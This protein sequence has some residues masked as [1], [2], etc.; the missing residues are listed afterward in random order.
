MT[1]EKLKRSL[2]WFLIVLMVSDIL[3][4]RAVAYSEQEQKESGVEWLSCPGFQLLP[5]EDWADRE[6]TYELEVTGT[7]KELANGVEFF[8]DIPGINMKPALSETNISVSDGWSYEFENRIP[9]GW[10]DLFQHYFHSFAVKLHRPGAG[11]GIASP[12]GADAVSAAAG[13][14]DILDEDGYIPEEELEDEEYAEA[15][16]GEADTESAG[17]GRRAA[18]RTATASVSDQAEDTGL[19]TVVITVTVPVGDLEIHPQFRP[20]S[21][22]SLSASLAGDG[23]KEV[24]E[25]EFDWERLGTPSDYTGF[26]QIVFWTDNHDEAEKRASVD[27]FK[28]MLA[29]DSNITFTVDGKTYPLNETTMRYV[30]IDELPQPEIVKDGE[31]CYRLAYPDDTFPTKLETEDGPHDV[32]WTFTQPQREGYDAVKVDENNF[33]NY[34]SLHDR[35]E[36][37]YGWYYILET[38]VTFDAVLRTGAS[39]DDEDPG[40]ANFN[41]ESLKN[42]LLDNYELEIIRPYHASMYIPLASMNEDND[43]MKFEVSETDSKTAK[44][45]VTN[46]WKYNIDGSR[47]QYRV[48]RTDMGRIPAPEIDTGDAPVGVGEDYLAPFYDNSGTNYASDTESVRNGGKLYL[49]LT[50]EA[51][52]NATKEWWDSGRKGINRPKG[53]FELWRYRNGQDYA[54]AAPVRDNNDKIVQC[55]LDNINDRQQIHFKADDIADLSS[56]PKYDPEGY[57]YVYVV[58]EYLEGADANHYQQ[59]FGEIDEE[60]AGSGVFTITDTLPT[61]LPPVGTGT[62]TGVRD[63]N[64]SYLYNGGVLSNCLNKNINVRA[65]KRW[66]S[67]AFQSG[68]EN[69]IV[70]MTLQS[71]PKTPDND[72]LWSTARDKNNQD[73]RMVKYGFTEED[74]AAWGMGASV[75]EYGLLGRELEYRWVETGV[76]QVAEEKPSKEELE[77]QYKNRKENG[78]KNLLDGDG[79]FTLAQ[80]GRKVRYLSETTESTSEDG[81]VTQVVTNSID[82]TIDYE[83]Q[84]K[85]ADG[86]KPAPVQFGLY[87]VPSGGSLSDGQQPYVEFEMSEAGMRIISGPDPHDTDKITAEPDDPAVATW[88]G[89]IRNLPEFDETGGGYQYLLLETKGAAGSVPSYKLKRDEYGNYSSVV[90]NGPGDGKGVMVR[91][92]WVD[93]SDTAHREPVTIQVYD[94]DH[95]AIGQLVTMDGSNDWNVLVGL[96]DDADVG[97]VYLREIKVAGRDVIYGAGGIHDGHAV[98]TYD[99]PY[100]SYEVTYPAAKV[101][102]GARFLTVKNRRTGA[103]NLTVDKYWKDNDGKLRAELKAA[104]DSLPADKKLKLSLRLKFADGTNAEGLGYFIL[105]DAAGHGQV[106][107]GTDSNAVPVVDDAKNPVSS[108]QEIALEPEADGSWP[109]EQHFYFFG[110]PKYDNTG[111]VVHY[112]V[113]E[114]WLDPDGGEHD[115]KE[116]IRDH[117]AN[118]PKAWPGLEALLGSYSAS[119][120]QGEYVAHEAKDPDTQTVKVTNRLTGT[121]TVFWH[122]LWDDAAVYR[123]HNRPDI[124]LDIFQVRYT[125]IEG[126]PDGAMKPNVQLYLKNYRWDQSSDAGM[127][128]VLDA[129][130]ATN[131]WHAVIDHLPKYDEETGREIFYYAVERAKVNI[132]QFDYADVTFYKA[133]DAA[134]AS[135]GGGESET[136]VWDTG[137]ERLERM[138]TARSTIEPQYLKATRDQPAW[139]IEVVD[140]PIPPN[141]DKFYEYPHFMLLEDG[142]FSN[143]LDDNVSLEVQK[144]WQALPGGDPQEVQL[145]GVTFG[146]YQTV[147]EDGYGS[148]DGDAGVRVATRKVEKWSDVNDNGTY[149]FVIRYKTDED[150]VLLDEDGNKLPNITDEEAEKRAAKLPEYNRNGQRYI[151]TLKEEKMWWPDGTV[152]DLTAENG[153]DDRAGIFELSQTD[154]KDFHAVN[155]YGG[156]KGELAVKK[157]LKLE[158]KQTLHADGTKTKSYVFPAVKFKLTRTYTKYNEGGSQETAAGADF[159]KE[160]IW[161]S[162]QVQKAYEEQQAAG[163]EAGYVTGNIVFEKVEKY[164]PNGSLYEYTVTEVKTD[165]LDGYET[166]AKEGDLLRADFDAE[167]AAAGD[168]IAVGGL[169]ATPSAATRAGTAPAAT[170][171]NEY[172]SDEVKPLVIQK[173]WKDYEDALGMRPQKITLRLKRYADAQAGQ[174][175]G[176]EEDLADVTIISDGTDS[177]AKLQFIIATPADVTL[178]LD[179]GAKSDGGNA[180]WKCTIADV[181]TVSPNGRPWKYKIT[182]EKIEGDTPYTNNIPAAPGAIVGQWETDKSRF[183]IGWLRNSIYR[184]IPFGKKWIDENGNEITENFLGNGNLAVTFAL[185]VKDGGTWQPADDYFK[186]KLDDAVY[187]KL[188]KAMGGTAEKAFTR[189][190]SAQIDKADSW[191]GTF[192]N[193]PRVIDKASPSDL[194]YRVVETAV[195]Y[196]GAKQELAIKD[197]T[198]DVPEYEIVK[199]D[200]KDPDGL[201][202]EA[203]WATAGNTT[204]NK[205]N[206][207]SLSIAKMWEGDSDNKYQTRPLNGDGKWVASFVVQ[208]STDETWKDTKVVETIRTVTLTDDGSEVPTV[209]IAG[210]PRADQHAKPYY[211]R[212]RELEPGTEANPAKYRLIEDGGTFYK[213]AYVTSYQTGAGGQVLTTVNRLQRGGTGPAYTAYAARKTW[214]P[215][216]APAGETRS[217]TVELQYY[218]P[219]GWKP[220]ARVVLDGKPDGMKTMRLR[221]ADET[222]VYGEDAEWHAVW[223]GVPLRHPNSLL[224]DKT[225]VT[226][227]R[228]AEVS[229]T[230]QEY[231]GTSQ[232]HEEGKCMTYEFVNIR[233]TKL[234]VEKTWNM[235]GSAGT[236]PQTVTVGLYRT[237]EKAQAGKADEKNRVTD[238]K[239]NPVTLELKAAAG[240]DPDAAWKGS[241]EKLASCE[242][243]DADKKPSGKPYYYYALELAVG[244]KPLAESG[245][246]AV[247]D[248]TAAGVTKIVNAP[249]MTVSGTKTW[250]DNGDAYR[251]RPQEITLRLERSAGGTGRWEQVKDAVPV[252]ENRDTDVWRY[253]YESLP[254]LSPD[255]LTYHYRVREQ[256]VENYTVTYEDAFNL[257]NRLDDHGRKFVF[258]KKWSYNGTDRL[259]ELHLTLYRRIDGGEAEAVAVETPAPDRQQKD[260]WVYTY[261][262][263]DR[264]DDVGREYTYWVEEACPDGYDTGTGIVRDGGTLVNVQ[265]GS[266]RVSKTVTGSRGETGRDFRFRVTFSGMSK[267]GIAA[268]SL[269]GRYG[270]VTLNAGT[271]QFTL[272]HNQSVTI[273]GLPAGLQYVVEETEAGRDGYT[274]TVPAGAAGTVEPGVTAEAPFKNRRGSTG[275]G[276]G[277]GGSTSDPKIPTVP[278]KPEAPGGNNTPLPTVPPFPDRTPPTGDPARTG[279]WLTVSLLSLGMM[280][281]LA[282]TGRKRGAG[283]GRRDGGSAGQDKD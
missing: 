165:F 238:D 235:G 211:Y 73:I 227:Y 69:V 119:V 98:G 42:A 67:A 168:E 234:D 70:E 53:T 173:E 86:A 120:E 226:R 140:V 90:T 59:I 280:I 111:R 74:L 276:G 112:T 126:A 26:E 94:K 61:W 237:T 92:E 216:T 172:H 108:I 20:G 252:W 82:N 268:D 248:N 254:K 115:L 193:V 60:V 220:L 105:D 99:S 54:S 133:K 22:L 131:H 203:F 257:T 76:Y 272:R 160:L 246:G 97:T 180:A 100:H 10:V 36:A 19:H 176:I 15:T 16:P 155:E 51:E 274:T 273:S 117:L 9:R 175:N 110:L 31:N 161:T 259:P 195:S 209:T 18:V 258:T 34:P 2:C 96:P 125:P 89:W 194:V 214:Y 65:V 225:S 29:T 45:T 121:K 253:T 135:G 242:D 157:I 129:G 40:Q 163:G 14:G 275:G 153:T 145:P 72:G 81:A 78:L 199:K 207:I 8:L 265:Q 102:A 136:K 215:Q 263:L 256:P 261:T 57:R 283:S 266:L 178:A 208:R 41:N 80:D 154:D 232:M 107:L 12:S 5:L 91:K 43:D 162:A 243:F 201:V 138:G 205:L 231:I 267:T 278:P 47:M 123:Q 200:P 46:G 24:V 25:T 179:T 114:V 33:V 245:F 1:K 223:N 71:R 75:A 132:K 32:T 44:V 116:Y 229:H 262:G 224:P 13:D 255:G 244:G 106:T 282:V 149:K 281:L 202:E 85:W 49:T 159:E 141:P 4:P 156:V 63:A 143:T 167:P 186:K 50:G 87:R 79:R 124:Y 190:L 6:L 158:E 77:K 128:E 239:G 185:Q 37:A 177:E 84:K 170:F 39:Y 218:S 197:L 164:A 7:A 38:T 148:P 62:Q 260:R 222:L 188:L 270:D 134:G 95:H 219:A 23:A 264:Y 30:G 66:R 127:E 35:G 241:F 28:E 88:H 187:Q 169:T 150:G 221:G 17:G 104:L 113:E 198:K 230:P 21:R 271:A 233:P 249:L 122:K 144:L 269:T 250:V 142:Y 171:L 103:V 52:Y 247:H 240:A 228:V 217:S 55:K 166:K 251:T 58:R 11:G 182:G 152:T 191:K 101:V 139:A 277:D 181:A 151:Y 48:K 192:R 189:T 212:V 3:S 118:Y 204:T 56:L 184:E 279:L 109:S 183:T 213:G 64:N 68:F 206:L 93:N 83:M 210:L 137:R 147:A 196:N 27:E 130:N 146:I 174:G 236:I